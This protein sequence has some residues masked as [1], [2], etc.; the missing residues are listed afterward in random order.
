MISFSAEVTGVEVFN[1]AFNRVSEFISDLRGVWPE[2]ARE[3]YAIETEQFRSEGAHGASGKWQGLSPAYA[4]YKAKAF[5]GQPTLK[6]TSSL[7]ESMTRPDA[8]DS[9]F[10]MEPQQ[11]TIGTQ[12]EG[13]AAHQRGNRRMPARPIISMTN[14]DKRRM[15]KAIQAGLVKFTRQAGFEVS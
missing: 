14:D 10:R 15:Q 7:Y 11:M 13:A 12:R 2:V 1:R 8:L 4:K 5:P 3:F 9:I 6:A